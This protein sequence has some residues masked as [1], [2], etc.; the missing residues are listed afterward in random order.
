MRAALAA[1]TLA[2]CLQ[3]Q[4]DDESHDHRRVRMTPRTSAERSIETYDG[5]SDDLLTAGLG[6]RGLAGR[7]AAVATRQAHRGGAAQRRDLQQLPRAGRRR[8]NGGYGTLYGPNVK[9]DGR[10]HT[11]DGRIAGEE[12]IAYADDGTGR[13]NVTLMVQIPSPSAPPPCIV[14]A[15]SSGSRGVYGAIGTAASGA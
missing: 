4:R 15:P 1:I 2:R 14:D 8:R 6:K 11:G 12:D 9:L 10:R 13:Q 3:P 5:T 7:R